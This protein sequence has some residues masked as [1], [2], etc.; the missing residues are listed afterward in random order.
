MNRRFFRGGLAIAASVAGLGICSAITASTAAAAIPPGYSQVGVAS[1]N[2]TPG[3]DV[4]TTCDA[5]LPYSFGGG[6]FTVNLNATYVDATLADQETQ[7]TAGEIQFNST[8]VNGTNLKTVGFCGD[9]GAVAIPAGTGEIFVT[10]DGP[11]L[12]TIAEGCGTTSFAT[13][14]KVTLTSLIVTPTP[15]S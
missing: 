7:N 8:G 14:G 12:N 1:Q 5:T 10:A 2:Y 11:L 3:G 6:C 13:T 4:G 9:S 15:T